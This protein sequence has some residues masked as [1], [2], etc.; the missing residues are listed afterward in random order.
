MTR[1][2]ATFT[3]VTLLCAA[4]ISS[5][6]QPYPKAVAYFAPRPAYPRLQNGMWPQ[7]SGIFTVHIDSKKGVVTGVSVK[8]ST[9]WEILDKAAM[10]ALRIWKFKTPSKPS[11]DV[12]IDFYYRSPH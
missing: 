7:G 9:G 2:V 3:A 6:A 5:V 8:K 10:S 12:P 4:R 1:Y 11:V